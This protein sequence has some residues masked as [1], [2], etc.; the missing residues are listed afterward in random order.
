M[1][2][3][4]RHSHTYS[5]I[6]W[7]LLCL[8]PNIKMGDLLCRFYFYCR[9]AALEGVC[10][11]ANSKHNIPLLLRNLKIFPWNPFRGFMIYSYVISG[12]VILS[13]QN[14]FVSKI[15]EQSECGLFWSLRMK[16]EIASTGAN[17][18]MSAAHSL[19]GA[20][21]LA[22]SS[23]KWASL[24]SKNVSLRLRRHTAGS[25]REVLTHRLGHWNSATTQTTWAI[26]AVL[27]VHWFENERETHFGKS[28][29]PLSRSLFIMPTKQATKQDA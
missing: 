18:L 14:I 4:L 6:K 24:F 23:E 9:L 3:F 22:S 25:K 12:A 20:L 28:P 13:A 10:F 26:C 27:Y 5:V 15:S 21:V 8:V 7:D 1:A 29:P 19:R 11:E 16:E 17:F 2:V